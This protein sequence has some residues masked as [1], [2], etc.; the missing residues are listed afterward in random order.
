M[1]MVTVDGL[2]DEQLGGDPPEVLLVDSEGH[3]P[4]VLRG[5]ERSL[6]SGR[7]HYLEF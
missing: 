7:V 2:V 4:M 1:R 3:D 5:A 6:A